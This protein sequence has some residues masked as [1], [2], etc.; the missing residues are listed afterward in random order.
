MDNVIWGNLVFATVVAGFAVHVWIKERRRR[1][2]L[3]HWKTQYLNRAIE[4]GERLRDI[5]K[6]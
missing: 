5:T 1:R 4:E 2:A 3:L 6:D